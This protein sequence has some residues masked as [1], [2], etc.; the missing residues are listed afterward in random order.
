MDTVF[1]LK[2]DQEPMP[3][4]RRKKVSKN[5]LRCFYWKVLKIYKF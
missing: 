1:L 2:V 3:T 5:Q 4:F